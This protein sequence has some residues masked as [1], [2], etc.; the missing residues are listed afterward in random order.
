[1]VSTAKIRSAWN[2]LGIQM[3]NRKASHTAAVAGKSTFLFSCTE[4]F[5]HQYS[6]L[7]ITYST[8]T[9]GIAFIRKSKPKDNLI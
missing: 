6:A 3:A 1:M 8:F 5:C 2:I 9:K 4:C 7:Y